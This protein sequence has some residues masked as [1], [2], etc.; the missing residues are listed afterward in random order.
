MTHGE[1]ERVCKER[2]NKSYDVLN[3][4]GSEYSTAVDRL[5]NFK[6]AALVLRT[7]PADAC[8]SFMT[9]HLVSVIDGVKSGK[10]QSQQW[11]D[12]K[13]GDLY[14]YVLLLEALL[15]ENANASYKVPKIE[16]TTVS[17][18]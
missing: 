6:E 18:G 2:F 9:K 15:R 16:V 10:P 4:K 14:N 12:E 8:L 5:H 3:A 7:T 17:G 1:F 11:I 13:I